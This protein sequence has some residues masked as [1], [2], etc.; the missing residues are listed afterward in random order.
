MEL[1]LSCRS[2]MCEQHQAPFLSLLLDLH[3]AQISQSLPTGLLPLSQFQGTS[4][5][6]AGELLLNSLVTTCGTKRRAVRQPSAAGS[7]EHCRQ[8]RDLAGALSAEQRLQPTS[9]RL[10]PLPRCPHPRSH[11]AWQ[12]SCK[13]TIAKSQRACRLGLP[14]FASNPN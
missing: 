8:S 5:P 6:G 1:H 11:T 10:S 4:F 2:S 14:F 7:G 13:S 12:S 9:S 3:F